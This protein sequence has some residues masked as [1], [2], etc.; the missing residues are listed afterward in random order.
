MLLR[1]TDTGQEHHRTPPSLGV[2]L[3][4]P[5]RVGS[6]MWPTTTLLQL[7]PG[8]RRWVPWPVSYEQKKKHS[9]KLHE[10]P[11][12]PNVPLLRSTSAWTCWPTMQHWIRASCTRNYLRPAVLHPRVALI[13]LPTFTRYAHTHTRTIH[14]P[15]WWRATS[16]K[17]VHHVYRLLTYR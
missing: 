5:S 15:S 12:D 9:K 7:W 16:C 10:I 6:P 13:R 11:P 14:F 17:D 2:H 8:V 4:R 3:S 1:A